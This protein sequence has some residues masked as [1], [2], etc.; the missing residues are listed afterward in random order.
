MTK[1]SKKTH[2]NYFHLLW[3][4]VALVAGLGPSILNYWVDPYEVFRQANLDK[5]N[6]EFAE[7][8]HYPLWKLT[9]FPKS[10]ST[11]IL[12]DS[13]ARALRDKYW[14]ELGIKEAYNFAYGG[15]TIPEIHSTFQKIKSNPNLKTLVVGIQLRSFDEAHKGGMNRVPEAIKVSASKLNYIKNWSVTKTSSKILLLQNPKLAAVYATLS[16]FV[17]TSAQAAELG[18]P[19]ALSLDRL[20]TPEI[21]FGCDLPEDGEVYQPVVRHSKGINLGLGRGDRLGEHLAQYAYGY[22]Q[23]PPKFDRQIL[24]NAKADWKNFQFSEKYF[25]MIAEIA[26]WANADP[27]RQLVFLI[28][29]TIP[30][31]Q[32]TIEQYGLAKIN[33]EMRLRLAALAPV[34]DFD[35]PNSVTE[36]LSNFSDAYHFNATIARALVGEISIALS[37]GSTDIT[38][39]AIKRRSKLACPSLGN[40]RPQTKRDQIHSDN[41]ATCRI[42]KGQ[43]HG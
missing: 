38:S 21:C 7:K 43:S 5:Q 29:P 31:M 24:R 12:G 32:A 25:D 34:F 3:V 16:D 15:G 41:T 27:E 39:K 9:H 13:R 36:D 28:P 6:A 17:S 26:I 23:L 10:T 20:L 11:V 14:H 2:R 1:Q 22:R 8:A 35:F 4:V 40:K 42:W 19:G 18:K 33:Q 37:S 30:E